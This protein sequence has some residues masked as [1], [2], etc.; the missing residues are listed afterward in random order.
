MQRPFV[1]AQSKRSAHVQRPDD[2]PT[3]AAFVASVPQGNLLETNVLHRTQRLL[4]ASFGVIWARSPSLSD[5]D[6]LSATTRSVPQ[7][8]LP[9]PGTPGLVSVII[10]T[11]NRGNLIRETIESLLA[12]TY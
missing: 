5:L 9:G 7:P 2:A 6:R 10:P 4:N 8:F 12:Q 1:N 3:R 11:Y